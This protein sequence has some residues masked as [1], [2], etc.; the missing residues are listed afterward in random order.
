M[1]R[2]C[3][4][5]A[6]DDVEKKC[7]SC[8]VHKSSGGSASLAAAGSDPIDQ[9]SR[10]SASDALSLGAPTTESHPPPNPAPALAERL[11]DFESG[12]TRVAPVSVAAA[13]SHVR[14]RQLLNI[15]LVTVS[16]NM[17]VSENSKHVW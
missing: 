14:H 17:T 8:A 9:I 1:I 3:K 16:Y 4:D 5:R 10:A 15:V 2:A 11:D 6:V 13:T 7:V 12:Q